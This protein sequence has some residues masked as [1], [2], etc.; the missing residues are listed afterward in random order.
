M[1]ILLTGP[2]GSGK[3]DTSWALLQ[4]FEQMIFLD[5]DWFASRVPFSWEEEQDV[6]SVYRALSSMLDFYIK[7]ENRNFVIPLTY[8]MA[9]LYQKFNHYFKKENLKIAS[10]RLRCSEHELERR[11]RE[12]DRNLW[13]KQQELN[14]MLEAQNAFD[15]KFP[16]NNIFKLIET[17]ELSEHEVAIKIASCLND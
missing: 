5:C 9:I 14:D 11:I 1:I 7:N 17:T 10:F 6:E 8:Q 3:T 12:R 13:Q 15:D 16:N 2:T 4:Q